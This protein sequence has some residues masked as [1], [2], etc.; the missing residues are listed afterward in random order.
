MTHQFTVSDLGLRLIKAYEGY[1]PESRVLISGGSVVGYG[2]RISDQDAI[3]LTREEAETI[4]RE[5]IKPV[6]ELVNEAVF[7]PLTQSQF[8]ALCS[9]AYNIGPDAFMR[10]DVVKAINNGRTLD[11]ANSFDVWRK[12][13]IDG[14]VFVVDALVRRRTAEKAL[15]LKPE[16]RPVTSPRDSLPP[17]R[18]DDLS[19][20]VPTAMPLYTSADA[21]GYVGSVPYDQRPNPGRR[22]E[23]GPSGI[24]ELSEYAGEQTPDLAA[25]LGFVPTAELPND[26]DISDTETTPAPYINKAEDGDQEDMPLTL[27][28]IAEAAAEVSNRLDALIDDFDGKE[29]NIPEMPDTLLTAENTPPQSVVLPFKGK[30]TGDQQ[31]PENKVDGEV[32]IPSVD[33][34]ETENTDQTSDSASRYI[35]RTDTALDAGSSIFAYGVMMIS[36][37]VMFGLSLYTWLNDPVTILGQWGPLTTLAGMIMGGV[38]ILASIWY[39]LKTTV[40]TS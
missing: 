33:V 31:P 37:L 35:D 17:V 3:A 12:G 19:Q 34:I 24:L 27:S 8:D 16:R 1:R 39:I 25:D 2:H 36:G 29:A 21:E 20:T 5:D 10:S 7:A 40:K 23:D 11:A 4:L 32:N 28:P 6:E 14:Q 18:D 13:E 15:F 22:R 26:L 38:I 30:E 9:L